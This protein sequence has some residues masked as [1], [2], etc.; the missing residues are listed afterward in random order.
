MK[1][2]SLK[3]IKHLYQN[4]Q[5]TYEDLLELV[6]IDRRAGLLA[7]VES[8]MRQRQR[9]RLLLFHYERMA[10]FEKALWF[11]GKKWIAGLDEVGRGPLAGP[12]VTACVILH[13]EKP[14]LG[15]RD[16]KKLSAIQRQLLDLEIRD[17]ALAFSIHAHS[18]QT[19]DTIN[20]LAATKDSMVHAIQQLPI[21]A[22][23]LLI[24]ALH[25]PIEVPQTSI[26]KGDDSSISIAA[27]SI[28]AKVFRDG[29]MQ[30][31]DPLYP[32]YGFAHNMGYGTSEHIAALKQHGPCPIHRL[33]FIRNF[34]SV[35]ES[36]G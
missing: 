5:W 36:I 7:F 35:N 22:E 25:L 23:H 13:P 33:S 28:L 9:E 6:K 32:V 19:I 15:L 26:I 24:D 10:T 18:A 30:T 1:D 12:V 31:Y 11:A 2:H 17:K 20:I 4:G 3:E 29:L 21:Q 14:I 16:S 27:A 34:L 8:C